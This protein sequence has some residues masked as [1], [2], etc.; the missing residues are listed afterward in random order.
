MEEWESAVKLE[1]NKSGNKK[2]ENTT[3][4]KKLYVVEYLNTKM[5]QLAAGA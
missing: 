3:V 2:T 5:T 4:Q 1:K